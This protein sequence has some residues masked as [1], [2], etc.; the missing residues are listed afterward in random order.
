GA[1]GEVE[2]APHDRVVDL[3]QLDA[4]PPYFLAWLR[5]AAAAPQFGVPGPGQLHDVAVE[6]HGIERGEAFEDL[7]HVTVVGAAPRSQL[8]LGEIVG[9]PARGQNVPDRF[10]DLGDR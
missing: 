5:F 7:A 3:G 10:G 9:V 6:R 2:P 4:Q 1:W 8:R